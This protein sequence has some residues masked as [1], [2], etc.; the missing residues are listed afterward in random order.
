MAIRLKRTNTEWNS[1]E[2]LKAEDLNDT[3]YAITDQGYVK[4]IA[5]PSARITKIVIPSGYMQFYFSNTERLRAYYNKLYPLND[6]FYSLGDSAHKFANV[7]TYKINNTDVGLFIT[8]GTIKALNK[9]NDTAAQVTE[10]ELTLKQSVA[11]DNSN[12]YL[13]HVDGIHVSVNNPSGSGANLH[14]EVRAYLDDG[15]EDTIYTNDYAENTSDDFWQH[16]IY[17]QITNGKAIKEIR[18]YAN[19]DT[20]PASGSEPTVQLV[21]VTGVQS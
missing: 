17:S 14:I 8:Q 20:A 15:T 7:W 9:G 5:D 10:T 11:P 2:V 1:Y 21:K 16:N 18:L 19:V 12:G 6:N 4:L 13:V 3:L